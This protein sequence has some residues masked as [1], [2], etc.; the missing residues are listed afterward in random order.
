MFKIC[1]LI[2]KLCCC[3]QLNLIV[4]KIKL[5]YLVFGL[6][7]TLLSCKP[8]TNNSFK[9]ESEL[10]FNVEYLKSLDSYQ[11]IILIQTDDRLG[12][13]GGNTFIVNIYMESDTETLVADY[14][15]FEGTKEPPPPPSPDE[16][17]DSIDNWFGH[18]SIITEIKKVKLTEND[19]K[20][21]EDAIIELIKHK[22]RNTDLFGHSGISN[23]IMYKDSSLIV[24]D[25][26]S[27]KW[28]N[29][30]KLKKSLLEK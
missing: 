7:L 1:F 15:E 13:W 9:P 20:L 23:R 29:F 3:S 18:K 16:S 27:I 25:Y 14:K 19:K 28:S 10:K 4:L 26:P 6:L 12:E 11:E 17:F 21:I 8:N 24:E 2:F 5:N 22:I 30:Q